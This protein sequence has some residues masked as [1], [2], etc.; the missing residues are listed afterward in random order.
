[1][2]DGR[3]GNRP[4]RNPAA[5]SN[6]QSGQRTDGGAGSKKQPIRVAPGGAYGER[7][8]LTEQQQG[9]P[10]SAGG[11]SAPSPGG[12]SGSPGEAGVPG[13][14]AFAPTQRPNEPNNQIANLQMQNPLAANPQAALRAMYG[15]YPHPAIKR[16]IDWSAY[17]SRPPR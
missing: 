16:L 7:K 9:A 3:G 6:P 1:M 12:P 15:R 17:G 5:V 11:A 14:G 4:P 13:G 10:M 2:P 8:A